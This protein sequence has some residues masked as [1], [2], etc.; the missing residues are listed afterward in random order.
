MC[1]HPEYTSDQIARVLGL[2]VK[3]KN[4]NI[5]MV[6]SR[7]SPDVYYDYVRDSYGKPIV[8]KWGRK[9]LTERRVEDVPLA[10]YNKIFSAKSDLQELMR[11]Y[12]I[13]R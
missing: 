4:G 3:D 12:G 13:V 9:I 1:F 10:S 7:R 2:I 5:R 11:L 6:Q 8:D